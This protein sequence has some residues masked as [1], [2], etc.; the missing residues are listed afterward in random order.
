MKYSTAD[1]M[2]EV[3]RAVYLLKKGYQ[4]QKISVCVISIVKIL[5]EEHLTYKSQYR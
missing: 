2:G 5:K 4:S 3:K 1:D